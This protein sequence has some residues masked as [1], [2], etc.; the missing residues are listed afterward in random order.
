MNFSL[1][2][3]PR[4]HLPAAILLVCLIVCG[5][6]AAE[7]PKAPPRFPLDV[8]VVDGHGR[9][10]SEGAP[11]ADISVLI[12]NTTPLAGAAGVA[13]PLQAFVLRSVRWAD[14]PPASWPWLSTRNGRVTRRDDGA[15][16][17]REDPGAPDSLT[18]EKGLLPP[19]AARA[20]PLPIDTRRERAHEVVIEFATV[21][22]GRDWMGEVLLPAT[23]TTG[24]ETYVP[25]A[26]WDAATASGVIES[27]VLKQSLEPGAAPLPVQTLRVILPLPEPPPPSPPVDPANEHVFHRIDW[28]GYDGTGDPATARFLFDGEEIGVGAS[29]FTEVRRRIE[30]MPR[31]SHL[32]V[33]PY[34]GDPGGAKRQYPFELETVLQHAQRAGIQVERPEAR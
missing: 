27:A 34:Y 24:V 5:L 10:G 6:G 7:A 17:F 14:R 33:I 31:G 19:G 16:E 2:R 11:G 22:P 3:C 23:A 13:M 8:T 12:R 28:R 25:T 21:A 18:V 9:F 15:I 1:S 20:I 32:V 4:R 29:G 30:A 26:G